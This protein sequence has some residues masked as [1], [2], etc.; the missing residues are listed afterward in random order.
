MTGRTCSVLAFRNPAFKNLSNNPWGFLAL[1]Y[2]VCLVAICVPVSQDAH[3]ACVQL[4]WSHL[5]RIPLYL[6]VCMLQPYST[7]NTRGCTFSLQNQPFGVDRTAECAEVMWFSCQWQKEKSCCFGEGD[8]RTMSEWERLWE[9][10]CWQE[11]QEEKK[12]K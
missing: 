12:S 2:Q 5:I 3:A 8:H 4:G 10:L 6:M 9:C 11:G 7:V 1:L